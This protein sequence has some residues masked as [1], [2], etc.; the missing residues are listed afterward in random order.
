MWLPGM[1]SRGSPAAYQMCSHDTRRGYVFPI[2]LFDL[3][4]GT[5]AWPWMH[6]AFCRVYPILLASLEVGMF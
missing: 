5:L 1:F 4:P 6:G 2:A 3:D